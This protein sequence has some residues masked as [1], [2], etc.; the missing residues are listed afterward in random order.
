MKRI[1]KSIFDIL[2]LVLIMSLLA[3]CTQSAGKTDSQGEDQN[4]EI[5]LP[6]ESTEQTLSDDA[7]PNTGT[8]TDNQNRFLTFAE[9][10][11]EF[12]ASGAKA[13]PAVQKTYQKL[14][15]L[16]RESGNKIIREIEDTS[17]VFSP[18]S[19]YLAFAT[20]A[21]GATGKGAE[22]LKELLAG[23]SDLSLDL[24]N[25]AS[26]LLIKNLLDN[27][28]FTVDINTMLAG[29]AEF[30]FAIDFLQKAA[31]YYEAVAV[32]MDFGQP[33]SLTELNRWT[34]EKTKGLIDPLFA[35]GYKLDLETSL[36]LINTVYFLGQWEAEFD[37][38]ATF[39]EV[40]NGLNNTAEIDMMHDRSILDYAESEQW[41]M[42]SLKYKGGTRMNLY[43]PKDSVKPKD[44][45][46]ATKTFETEEADVVLTLPKFDLESNIGLSKIL[47]E[48][49]PGIFANGSLLSIMTDDEA[50]VDLMV[51]DTFQ[52]ARVKVDEQGTEAAAATVIVAPTAIREP[53]DNN[54]IVLKFDRSFAW[55]IVY[56]SVPL[57][58][59]VVSDLP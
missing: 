50:P 37:P 25:Q 12:D 2:A 51:G 56:D 9:V 41:Q 46:L 24:L 19:Y 58:T 35:K 52:K 42:V 8:E 40:F 20:L 27:A 6:N 7:D 23:S 31:S 21:N 3:G 22:E 17:F 59:G 36:I 29:K 11:A 45:L 18:I 30:E 39:K 43:L 14:G 10:D 49:V 53:D 48:L 38:D 15:E 33:E 54:I 16:I 1:K 57:F 44:I 13:N 32:K 55:E 47:Q 28:E 5:S 34:K 26:G 4:Q